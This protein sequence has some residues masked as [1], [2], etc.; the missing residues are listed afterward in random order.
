MRPR[1]GLDSELTTEASDKS[2]LSSQRGNAGVDDGLRAMT[3]C[4]IAVWIGYLNV[5]LGYRPLE[6]VAIW[7]TSG[8]ERKAGE[9]SVARA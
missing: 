2:V 4:V 1:S 8:K 5:D 7:T 6:I 9:V 3:H